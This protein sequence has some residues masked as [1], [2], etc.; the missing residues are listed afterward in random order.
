MSKIEDLIR[1]Y[2]PNGCEWKRLGDTSLFRISRGVVISKS[3]IAEH[4]GQYPV[5]SS[6]TENDGCLGCIDTYDV[7]GERITWTTDGA[8]AGT[9]FYRSGKYNITNVCGMIECVSSNISCKYVS[10]VL[11]VEAPKFVNKAM[12][13]CKLMSNVVENIQIPIPPLPIQK[14]IVRIL[15]EFTELEAELEAKLSE[16]IELKQKQYA[17]YRDKL[18]TFK[19]KE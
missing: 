4:Q 9:V 16:E 2:C 19:R 14:E 12:G 10:Y 11:G 7:D 1:Q 8:K 15:D 5:Y 3:Y 6:Q 18:L 13:N 17:Y